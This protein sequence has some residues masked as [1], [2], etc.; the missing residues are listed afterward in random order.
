MLQL[1]AEI[2][3]ATEAKVTV[4]VVPYGHSINYQGHKVSFEQGGIEIPDQVPVSIDHGA[5]SLERIGKLTHWSE[6]EEGLYATLAISDTVAGRDTLTLMRDGVLTDVS[7][8]V[9]LA[10]ELGDGPMAGS[11]DHVSIVPKGAFGKAGP[12]SKV[13]AASY[14][15][16]D[17]MPEEMA[18][19]TEATEDTKL[20][21]AEMGELRKVIAEL[22]VPGAISEPV[23]EFADIRDFALTMAK[24]SRGDGAAIKRIGE[25]ALAD[26]TTTTAAGVVPD[27]LSTRVIEIVDTNRPYLNTIQK[28]P[29]GTHGMSVVYP[30]VVSGPSVAVQ[31]TQ[32]TEVSSTAM[33]ID[34]RSVDLVTYA[35]ASDVARQLIERSQ[36]SFVQIL[37]RHYASAYAQVTDGAAV[38]AAVAGA[39]NTA[40]LADLGADAAATFAAVNAANEAIIAAVRKPATH[41]ALAA[42]RWTQLNSLVDSTGRPLLVYGPNGP[43]NAQGQSDFTAEVAQYHGLTAYLDANATTGACL[44]YNADLY[45]FWLEQ[46]P[47]ELRAEVVSL[48][49]FELGVYGLFAHEVE[50]AGAGSTLTLV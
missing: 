27:Y 38:N 46:A 9:E 13:L 33:D 34:P 16:E 29:I 35:G 23:Q 48:L 40:I 17:E 6:T 7:A 44:I 26:D 5:G 19:T 47:I 24:A 41:M 18:A 39:G 8:G 4:R 49:G 25:F 30:E 32:K 2:A 20:L 28:D 12:G 36:P 50:H 3:E 1:R 45:A 14:Q 15:G 11:L 37:F 10:T 43:T 22:Q 21:A 31:A 42:D